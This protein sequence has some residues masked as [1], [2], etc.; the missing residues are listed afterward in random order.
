MASD[1]SS[2]FLLREFYCCGNLI[3]IA[4]FAMHFGN[5]YPECLRV[6]FVKGPLKVVWLIP[7]AP[8]VHPLGLSLDADVCRSKTKG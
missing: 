1:G 8:Q 4:P 2:D 5:K 3:V 6:A 7:G